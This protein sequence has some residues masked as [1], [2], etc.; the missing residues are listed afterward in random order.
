MNVKPIPLSVLTDNVDLEKYIGNN[1]QS[2]SGVL[3]DDKLNIKNVKVQF[4]D[5]KKYS[6]NSISN[7]V[8]NIMFVD[9]INSSG[10]NDIIND[11]NI[12]SKVTFN[13]KVYTIDKIEYLVPFDNLHHLE[14]TLI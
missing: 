11:F 4:D 10:F 5:V 9:A 8:E 2:D 3:Y 1:G 13:G 14:V 12:K 6:Q 7:V